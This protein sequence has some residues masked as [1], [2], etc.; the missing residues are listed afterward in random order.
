MAEAVTAGSNTAPFCIGSYCLGN[1]NYL[2]GSVS[3][4]QFYDSA[5]SPQQI[6]QLYQQGISGQPYTSSNL[7][8]WWP[9][10]G[11]AIDYSGN[12]N[13][14]ILYGNVNFVS[15]SSIQ[16]TNANQT[17]VL[18]GSFNGLSSY[19][20]I[21]NFP[22]VGSVTMSALIEPYSYG[23]ATG[24]DIVSSQC[25]K[26]GYFMKMLQNGHMGF[27]IQCLANGNV[28]FS[29]GALP[30]NTMTLVTVA[31]NAS[32]NMATAY[33]N[34]VYQGQ[35]SLGTTNTIFSQEYDVGTGAD[36][37][38][39]GLISNLQI[40]GSA[41]SASQ[42][43]TLYSQSVSA[44]PIRN[45][46]LIGWWPLNGNANDL[47]SNGNNGTAINTGFFMQSGVPPYLISSPSGYGVNFNGQNSYIS[48][49]L[50]ST[51]TNFNGASRITIAGWVKTPSTISG[52]IA[53]CGFQNLALTSSAGHT[54]NPGIYLNIGGTVY[55]VF[56]PSAISANNWYYVAATYDGTN[57]RV[58]VNGVQVNS[59]VEPG[60]ISNSN[61]NCNAGYWTIGK[62]SFGGWEFGQIA[63]V[64][65]YNTVL[66][67]QQ[68][69]QLYQSV[70]PPYADVTVPLSW[71][72]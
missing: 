49:P 42:V 51:L 48:I 58:Y 19:V 64:Q 14:G 71:F 7:G 8:G 45:S 3:D 29:G 31:Y 46:G 16:N 62:N 17:N 4:V 18:A 54:L 36:G 68:I 10:N 34:G 47:S 30:L 35:S 40:Y 25:S 38:F 1:S 21:S 55:G 37:Y 60:M 70:M 56:D 57:I 53:D 50:S 9:L 61:A 67:A 72:P 32:T 63:D 24:S 5:L 52:A 41:L 66:T 6:L 27:G 59:Q 2:K 22:S 33:A 39:N 20:K 28:I 15:T 23:G 44:V 12:G 11:D 65:I 43:R 69:Q 13:N 26:S